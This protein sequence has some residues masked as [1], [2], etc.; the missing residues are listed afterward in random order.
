MILS[1]PK[2]T[3]TTEPELYGI[4]PEPKPARSHIPDWFKKLK[5]FQHED[6]DDSEVWPN[7]TI[8]RCPP[9]LDAM[10]SGYLMVTPAEIEIVVNE[11]GSGV[12][13]RTD[14]FRG[15]IEPHEN[16]Q[17]KGHH[18]LPS[19]PLKFMNYWHLKTP[20]GWSTLFVPPLNRENNIIECM[21]GIVET[22]KYFEYVNFPSFIKQRGTTILL[23]RGYP[24]AQAIPFKRGMEKT[25]EIRAMNKKE[26]VH[27][28][29]TRDKR[30]SHPSLYR[31]TMWERK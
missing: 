2:V 5:N 16:S 9:F 28:K 17:I 29:K 15:V 20:P 19:P 1:K 23:P 8:K 26:L 6:K 7:R 31:E 22:D 13:W 25:A 14:F 30:S 11:D 27:L 18:G 12:D 4:I 21:S 3:F 10:V 24:I